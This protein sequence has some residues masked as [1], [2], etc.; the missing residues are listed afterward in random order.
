[1]R[2]KDLQAGMRIQLGPTFRRVGCA[3]VDG[4]DDVLTGVVVKLLRDA[5]TEWEVLLG[6]DGPVMKLPLSRLWRGTEI[7][8][9]LLE[10]PR[11]EKDKF[12]KE[13]GG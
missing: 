7:G 2:A 11:I 5:G 10:S 6:D 4:P 12:S 9:R 1:M 3:L 8:L 13:G